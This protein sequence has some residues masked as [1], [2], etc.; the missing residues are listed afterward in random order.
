MVRMV[1]IGMWFGFGGK[2]DD[3]DDGGDGDKVGVWW[4]RSCWWWQE[5]QLF[6]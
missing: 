1:V 4:W 2:L 6:W 5:Y 3:G